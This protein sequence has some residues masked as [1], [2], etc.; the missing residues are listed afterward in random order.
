MAG[1]G[2]MRFYDTRIF[3]TSD[4]SEGFIIAGRYD[5]NNK[6]ISWC[7]Y[8]KDMMSHQ[9]D[10]LISKILSYCLLSS[11][12]III[13]LIELFSDKNSN[14]TIEMLLGG[15]SNFWILTIV[16]GLLMTNVLLY[17]FGKSQYIGEEISQL[18][19]IVMKNV[20]TCQVDRG[21]HRHRTDNK[22]L[23]TFGVKIP[24][25][26]FLFVISILLGFIAAAYYACNDHTLGFL[27]QFVFY[28]ILVILIASLI[29]IIQLVIPNYYELLKLEKSIDLKINS[30]NI[31]QL[32]IDLGKAEQF[33]KEHQVSKT[34]IK[35]YLFEYRKL[36]KEKEM[37]HN[38]R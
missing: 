22:S 23:S 10:K 3:I 30:F 17:K 28:I 36:L 4:I 21:L 1:G 14:S 24:Y 19:L 33:Y 2:E 13:P 11:P 15:V 25:L 38:T 16:F 5:K 35:R 9:D 34:G 31:E 8:S 12:L 18:S 27:G 37:E 32:N 20:I 26:R 6:K 7:D 29:A